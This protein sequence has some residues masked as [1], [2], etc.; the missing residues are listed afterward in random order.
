MESVRPERSDPLSHAAD[1]L[2][3]SGR[4]EPIAS[5]LVEA[6]AGYGRVVSRTPQ[7]WGRCG[8]AR[9]GR[10]T[11]GWPVTAVSTLMTLSFQHQEIMLSTAPYSRIP[12]ARAADEFALTTVLLFIAGTI[13]RWLPDPVSP[14]S[15][16]DLNVALSVIA[17]L[18]GA[19]LTGL[20]VVPADR[21]SGG[22][23]AGWA[24]RLRSA[25]RG[26]RSPRPPLA[27]TVYRLLRCMSKLWRATV[28]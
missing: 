2:G 26:R 13:V 7:S 3:S 1:R 24:R 21:R 18:S 22:H 5:T 15:I 28:V 14:P 11:A 9:P 6:W 4:G 16:A 19:I 25:Q 23:K 27:R 17:V 20:I 10:T 8:S 12:L